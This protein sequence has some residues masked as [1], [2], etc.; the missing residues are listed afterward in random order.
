[1]DANQ[2]GKSIWQIDLANLPRRSICRIDLAGF[3]KSIWQIDLANQFGKSIRQ[4][5]LA[6]QFEDKSFPA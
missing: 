1:L 3:A 2:F 5:D 4:I 6:N